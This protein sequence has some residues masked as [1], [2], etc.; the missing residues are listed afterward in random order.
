MR[1]YLQSYVNEYTYRYNH[2]DDEA[3][4]FESLKGRV[5]KTRYGRHGEYAPVGD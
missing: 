5:T 4:M 3:P 1:P 2:L